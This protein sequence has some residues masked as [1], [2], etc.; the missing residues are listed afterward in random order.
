MR[1][2]GQ[3]AH[4][5]IQTESLRGNLVDG[6][7]GRNAGQDQGLPGPV[8][9]E[10]RPIPAARG[11]ALGVGGEDRGIGE[12]DAVLAGAL[13]EDGNQLVDQFDGA[14]APTG[15]GNR[16]GERHQVGTPWR[17]AGRLGRQLEGRLPVD[18]ALLPA[19]REVATD[20]PVA[21]AVVRRDPALGRELARLDGLDHLAGET[22]DLRA[23][24]AAACGNR[25][26]Y[27]DLRPGGRA[28]G[29]LRHGAVRPLFCLGGGAEVGQAWA[30]RIVEF[31][32][33]ETDRHLPG[34]RSVALLAQQADTQAAID[35]ARG[36]DDARLHRLE[37]PGHR[38]GI[39]GAHE[40]PEILLV[41]ALARRQ[42]RILPV[43]Q[44]DALQVVAF[45]RQRFHDVQ[46]ALDH[47]AIARHGLVAQRLVDRS[48]P[49]RRLVLAMVRGERQKREIALDLLTPLQVGIRLVPGPV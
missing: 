49:V 45:L 16:L 42:A 48:Q 30:D 25:E 3:K 20:G 23:V 34:E 38:V 1:I 12:I 8:P 28:A 47:F 40:L 6:P 26:P 24:A 10:D 13:V 39:V 14:V 29:R 44:E 15:A 46:P 37:V 17:R 41:D 9:R 7:A 33:R 21:I 35:D 18:A 36:F 43:D 32:L 4:C 19:P 11:I 22:L 27:Q 31:G 5:P 2:R